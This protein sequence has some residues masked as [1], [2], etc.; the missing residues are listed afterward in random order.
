[1]PG[2]C[3][4]LEGNANAKRRVKHLKT[5]LSQIG[6][7]PERVRMFNISAAMAGEFVNAV[8]DMTKVIESVGPNPLRIGPNRD[9]N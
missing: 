7:Q 5:L 4:Y 2:D 1:M 8:T 9:D 3:H 6:L